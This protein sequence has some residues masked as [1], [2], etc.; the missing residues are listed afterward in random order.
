MTDVPCKGCTACCR[1]ERIILSSEHGD[2]PKRYQ[3]VPSRKGDGE[4]YWMLA[5]K[6]NGDCIY[7]TD[8]GCSIHGRAP[9]ACRKFDCRMW[10]LGFPEAM[11]ELL[12]P[13]D[14]DG[15]VVKAAKARLETLIPDY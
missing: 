11:Q 4:V 15:E 1:R 9:Y 7:L 5:H 8:A 2:D 6:P 13:D 10:L 12:T 3:V 14:L